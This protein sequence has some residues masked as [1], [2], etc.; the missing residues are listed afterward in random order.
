MASAQYDAVAA[1]TRPFEYACPGAGPAGAG[2]PYP[3]CNDATA[4]ERRTGY[5]V[6]ALQS[7]G[8]VEPREGLVLLL[9]RWVTGDGVPATTTAQP[10]VGLASVGC[11]LVADAAD[12]SERFAVVLMRGDGIGLLRFGVQRDDPGNAPRITQTITGLIGVN[13]KMVSGGDDDIPVVFGVQENV[14]TRYFVVN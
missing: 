6:A 4:G 13:P 11:P 10:R 5:A 1:L 9:G 14:G 7:E 12:C 2:A 3:L 8:S